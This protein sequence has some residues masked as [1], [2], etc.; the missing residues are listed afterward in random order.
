MIPLNLIKE[1]ILGFLVKLI[2]M[3]FNQLPISSELIKQMGI[4]GIVKPTMVQEKVIPL[5]IENRDVI[6]QSETGSGKTIGF[7]APTIDATD[8]EGVIRVL[9]IAPTRELALQISGEYKKLSRY[10]G[11]SVASVYGGVG[12]NDQIRDVRRADVVIGTPGRILDLINRNVMNLSGV[13]HLVFDEADRLLD[14]GFSKDINAIIGFLPKERQSLM[15]SATVNK[16]IIDL[17]SKYMNSPVKVMLNNVLSTDLLKQYYYDTN[18]S[19]KNALLVHLIKTNEEGLKLVFCNTKYKTRE[20]ARILKTNRIKAGFINGDLTQNNRERVISDFDSG[21]IKV[22]V[23]TD[24]AARGLDIN[25][26]THVFNYELPRESET[27]AHRIGRTAR[28]GKKGIAISLLTRQD[29]YMM[30]LIKREY[31]FLIEKGS[32]VKF[33]AI[34]SPVDFFRP[35]NRGHFYDKKFRRH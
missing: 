11:L 16:R 17:S 23:A 13:K 1:L 12:I 20:L 10:K 6:V 19:D 27:Y 28:N 18:F 35:V 3:E 29:N 31:K 26:I 30:Q 34:S 22:L 15:F 14:M 33:S 7:A 21:Y 5:V 8:K 24:V 32:P 2:I 9:V 25:D 4:N